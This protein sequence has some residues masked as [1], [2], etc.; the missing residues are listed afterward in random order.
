[1]GVASPRWTWQRARHHS[2]EGVQARPEN[3]KKAGAASSELIDSGMYPEPPC[4]F[5]RDQEKS[6]AASGTRQ[7]RSK[8]F[9]T[10]QSQCILPA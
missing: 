3:K 2:N 10:G 7:R 4:R 8:L 6:L 9:Y 5:S 1:M